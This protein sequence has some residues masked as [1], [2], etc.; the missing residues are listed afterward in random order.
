MHKYL[1]YCTGAYYAYLYRK[2][3][4]YSYYNVNDI[5]MIWSDF[6]A[7]GLNTVQNALHARVLRQYLCFCYIPNRKR[8]LC[9]KDSLTSLGLD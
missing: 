5:L 7:T 1:L 2:S 9:I 4:V 8:R 6:T 3:H